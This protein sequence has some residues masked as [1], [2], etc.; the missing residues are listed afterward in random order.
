MKS[1]RFRNARELYTDF[2]IPRDVGI[3]ETREQG[4]V[5]GKFCEKIGSAP[6]KMVQADRAN[7]ERQRRGSRAGGFPRTAKPPTRGADSE[8]AQRP[9]PTAFAL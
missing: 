6:Q 4:L 7:G 1:S 3:E 8:T 5:D 2:K 9:E